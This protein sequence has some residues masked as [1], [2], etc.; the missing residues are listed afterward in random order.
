MLFIESPTACQG[1]HHVKMSLRHW[2]DEESSKT[3]ISVEG[4][5]ALAHGDYPIIGDKVDFI[6]F[7]VPYTFRLVEKLTTGDYAGCNL[8]FN[9]ER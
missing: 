7:G 6:V 4:A 1:L 2:Q 8:V 9:Y 5:E 3:Q